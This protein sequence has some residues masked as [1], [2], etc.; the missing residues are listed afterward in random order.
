MHT[1]LAKFIDDIASAKTAQELWDFGLDYFHAHGAQRVSYHHFPLGRR[2]GMTIHTDGFPEDWVCHY[3]EDQLY[4]V[5][6]RPDLARRMANVFRWSDIDQIANLHEEQRDFM[7]ELS[8]WK[9]GDGLAIPLFGPN[10]RNG[11]LGLGFGGSE[12]MPDAAGA[13]ALQMAAQAGHL[14]Y[15]ELL[16]NDF[17]A[18]ANLSKREREIL[19]WIAQGKSNAVIADILDISRHTVDTYVRRL[20]EKLNVSDRTSAAIVGIGSSIVQPA[21]GSSVP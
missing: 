1:D 19:D 21:L 13:A 6:P 7:E 11:Y 10:L 20:F 8:H 4:R 9:L 14:R 5:D 17:T 15:C 12:N 3:I 18:P 16:K 2:E